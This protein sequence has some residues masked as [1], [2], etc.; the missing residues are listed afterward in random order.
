[1]LRLLARRAGAQWPLLA[2]LVGVVMIGASLLGTCALLVTR[3]ADRAL[4][5][6]A[7]RAVPSDVDITAYTVNVDGGDARSV[8]ADAESVLTEGVAPFAATMSA[9]ASSAMRLLPDGP[10]RADG[11]RSQ[12]Y[13]SAVDDLAASAVLTSGRWPRAAVQPGVPLEA[14]VLE[15]TARQLGVTLGSRVRLGDKAPATPAPAVEVSVVGI[16]RPLPATGWDRDPLGGAGYDLAR[17]DGRIASTVPVYGPLLVDMADLLGCGCDLDRLQVTAHPD[18]SHATRAQLDALT[19][20][21]RTVERHLGGVLGERS[22]Y[23]HTASQLPQTLQAAGDQQQVTTATVLVVAVLGSVLTAAALALAARLTAS[24]RAG[25]TALLSAL[26]VSRGQLAIAATVEAGVLAALAAALALAIST[27]L[28]ATLTHLPPMSDAGLAESPRLG[29]AQIVAVAVGALALAAVLVVGAGQPA[30]A[31]AERD[32]RRELLARSGADLL[33]AAFAVVG[34]WQLRAQPAQANPRADAVRVVAP[35]ILLVAG[36]ALT[37]RLAPPALRAVDRLARRA[38]GLVLPL[39]AFEAARRRQALAAGLLVG[40][41]CAVATFATAFDATWQRSQHD[42]ADLSV[43]TDLAVT[44]AAGPALGQGAQLGAATGGVVSPVVDRGVAVGEYLGGAGDPPRL[45][46]VDLTRAGALVRGRGT[47]RGW[48]GVAAA[49]IPP[50]VRGIDVPAGADFTLTGTAT[51]PTPVTVTPQLLLQDSTGLRTVCPAGSVPLD[52]QPHPLRACP[53]GTALQ[54]IAV[55]L[56]VTTVPRES[57]DPGAASSTI[58]VTLTVPGNGTGTGAEGAATW[59][60]QATGGEPSQL[61]AA[62]AT[63][64]G[65]Q[66]RMT[67]AVGLDNPY[68]EG[69]RTLLA[70]AFPDPGAVPVAISTRLADLIH[71]HVGSRLAVTV[72]STQVPIA[73]AATVPAVPS[74]PGAAAVLADADAL[75]RALIVHGTLDFPLDAWWVGHPTRPDAVAQASA[76]HLGTVTTRDSEATRLTSGPVRAGLPAAL[77]LLGPAAVLLLL[78]GLVLHVTCDMHLRALE[79]ARLRGLGMT[80]RNI[81]GVLLGQ[82][83]GVLLPLLAAGAIVGALASWIVAP[84]LVRAE[85]GGLPVPAALPRWPWSAEAALLGLLL[86]GCLLAVTV[87]VSIQ[88]RRAD[89]AHLRVTS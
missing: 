61:S 83:A 54:L 17:P 3:S 14:V 40:L 86:A 7:A 27:A 4:E 75:S 18:L 51:G 28:Y 6:A 43:G 39:A 77:R 12:A 5:V 53:A 74:A 58:T 30:S 63:L 66:L 15:T 68:A 46:A 38:R 62:S 55:S 64:S 81:R 78:A 44:G 82:H 24:V 89:A 72:G 31:S 67:A 35:T 20:H 76:L 36:T 88:A 79:V 10:I 37:L 42:Q 1:M 84:R 65:T 16:A 73:V 45:V 34:W 11:T 71:V 87:V 60:A 23:T 59:T 33:L 9:R 26:G 52:G 25:E 56:P 80:R 13:L 69:G 85:T 49:L 70:T 41:A 32:A 22:E 48:G 47:G 8:M 50:R 57:A 2:A 19:A 29:T 21:L